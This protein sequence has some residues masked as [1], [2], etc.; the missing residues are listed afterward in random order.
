MLNEKTDFETAPS[1]PATPAASAEPVATATLTGAQLLQALDYVAPD[2]DA[3]QLQAEAVIAF[4]EGHSGKGYYCWI[5]DCPEEGAI[6]L[7]EALP[8]SYPFPHD[9]VAHPAAAERAQV[10]PKAKQ[11][12]A[13]EG[14]PSGDNVP[15]AVCGADPAPQPNENPLS[16]EY[17]NAVIRR[18]GYDSP[19]CVVARLHQ[20]IGLH[21]GENGVT[22]LMYEAHK[23]L[24][25][26]RTPVADE[27]AAFTAWLAGSYPSAY[28][29]PE[30]VRLWHH[31]HVAALAWQE[32]GRRAALASALVAG[33]A[34]ADDLN[35]KLF[36]AAILDLAAISEH[37]GLDPDE[38][39][40]EPIIGAID[41]LRRERDSWVNAQRAAD[42]EAAPQA[43]PAA[44][45][46]DAKGLRKANV[47]LVKLK[48]RKEMEATIPRD[49][50]GWWHDVCPGQH[51]T[52]RD[53]T[54]DD[55]AR[56]TLNGNRSKNP[57]DYLCELPATGSL[58][59]KAAIKHCST[60]AIEAIAAQQG[61]GGWV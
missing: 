27:R 25:K 15:C 46:R 12:V 44:D 34:Q 8:E 14:A 17:V 5:L 59:S 33:E 32:R 30:A 51:M 55:L 18:H 13:C 40:A 2:R 58:I 45:G 24:V 26:L 37:L 49:H 23:A 20:W 3:D 41:E 50:L 28:S 19:E 38:G 60:Y 9:P 7:E 56:C 4:G 48:S 53:A 10:A 1:R 47:H 22:L 21:G 43:S 61:E 54:A 16:D 31:R 11:C 39:G 57:A 35:K 42:G 36:E 52:L 6:M 29:E